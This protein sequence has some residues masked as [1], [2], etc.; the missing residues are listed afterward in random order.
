MGPAW[1]RRA[2]APV[3]RAMR[4]AGAV[5]D[6]RRVVVVRVPRF[7]APGRW[8]VHSRAHLGRLPKGP[9]TG[10]VARNCE[11]QARR[12]G[13]VFRTGVGPRD[14][15]SLDIEGG[16]DRCALDSY[17]QRTWRRPRSVHALPVPRPTRAWGPPLVTRG[18]VASIDPHTA[19]SARYE[20]CRPKSIRTTTHMRKARRRSRIAHTR[21]LGHH[22]HATRARSLLSALARRGRGS[23]AASLFVADGEMLRRSDR[24]KR[25][26]TGSGAIPP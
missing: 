18:D 13:Q 26:L 3:I 6:E 16:N 5:R 1:A 25:G 12:A 15:A 24:S 11:T 7:S 10:A 9:G 8:C 22:G 19:F 14:H 20:S 23:R 21:T 4:V 17:S 2:V